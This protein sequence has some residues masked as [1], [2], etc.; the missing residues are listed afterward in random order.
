MTLTAGMIY[1]NVPIQE[2]RAAVKQD[3]LIYEPGAREY[4]VGQYCNGDTCRSGGV[5][6]KVS[7]TNINMEGNMTQ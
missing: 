1:I 4:T 3:G 6:I 7:A 2:S 5:L